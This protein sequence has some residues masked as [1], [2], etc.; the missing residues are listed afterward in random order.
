M[1]RVALLSC[2]LMLAACSNKK[3]EEKVAP[4]RARPAAV[5]PPT[6]GSA[7]GSAVTPEAMGSAEA[8]SAATATAP[9][10]ATAPATAPT[11]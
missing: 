4:N 9:A 1:I 5:T 3:D 2:V 6:A 7:A 10:S 8:G 11:P